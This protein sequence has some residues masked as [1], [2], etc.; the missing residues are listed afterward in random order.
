MSIQ[1]DLTRIK[2]A[3]AAIKTAIEGKGVTV[4]DGTMLDGMAALIDGIQAGGGI[5]GFKMIS[6]TYTPTENITKNTDVY[7]SSSIRTTSSKMEKLI[8]SIFSIMF[9]SKTSNDY[10]IQYPT[11]YFNARVWGVDLANNRTNASTG[12][13]STIG[14]TLYYTQVGTNLYEIRASL[15]AKSTYPLV[16]GQTYAWML[17]FPDD[18]SL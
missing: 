17:I 11:S 3:K 9:V 2:N 10:T 15:L 5:P 14:R 4:P 18:I 13:L 6:G 12:S 16:A 1:T 7:A 8:A